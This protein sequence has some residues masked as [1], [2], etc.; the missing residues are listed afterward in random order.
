MAEKKQNPVAGYTFTR[1]DGEGAEYNETI[2][3]IIE[4]TGGEGDVLSYGPT[5]LVEFGDGK[6]MRAYSDELHPWYPT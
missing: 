3:K 6:R 1:P 2:C 4:R 5:F